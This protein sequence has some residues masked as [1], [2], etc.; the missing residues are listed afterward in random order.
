MNTGVVVGAYYIGNFCL[1]P[2]SF[3]SAFSGLL[4]IGLTL[5]VP[6]LIYRLVRTY[7]DRYLDGHIE[8]V[9]ALMYA[10][11]IMAFGSILAA[12]AHYI[13]FAFIDGG[14]M[15]G[16]L[17]QSIEQ[18]SAIDLSTLGTAGNDSS[19]AQLNQ[20]IEMMKTTATQI[21][22]LTPIDITMGMLSNNI[23]WAIIIAFPIALLTA[24]HNR[25]AANTLNQ[26][27]NQ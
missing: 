6:Y 2:L 16:A 23:S 25:N 3:S 26:L 4:F 10:M 12:A 24:R 19:I 27:N 22:A 21:K 7:R 11:L 15:V 14:R 8:F 5:L 9:Q 1:F 13:Y 18:F 20:Y 17:E